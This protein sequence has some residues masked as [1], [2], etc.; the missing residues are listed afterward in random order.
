[1]KKGDKVLYFPNSTTAWVG[2]VEYVSGKQIMISLGNKLKEVPASEVS[3]IK[4]AP[5]IGVFKFASD[6]DTVVGHTY[7]VC[8]ACGEEFE[9][10][11]MA[12][13]L[14]EPWLR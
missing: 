5:R 10:E 12:G 4:W 1:M 7:A 3:P 8:P 13:D 2:R 9:V 11:V 6:P 14:E